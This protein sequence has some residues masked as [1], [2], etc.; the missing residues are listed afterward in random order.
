MRNIPRPYAA[1]RQMA[2]AL[3]ETANIL[4]LL[5]NRQQYLNGLIIRLLK[6]VDVVNAVVEEAREKFSKTEN[7]RTKDLK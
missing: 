1:G 5:D 6:E 2:E 7:L 3:C 4:Y